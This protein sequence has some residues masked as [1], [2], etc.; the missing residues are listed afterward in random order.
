MSIYIYINIFINIHHKTIQ[1]ATFK[2]SPQ[3]K[4]DATERKAWKSLEQFIT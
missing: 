2:D 3:R 4:K 1:A